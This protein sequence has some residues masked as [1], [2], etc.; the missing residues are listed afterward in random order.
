MHGEQTPLKRPHL[1]TQ[2]IPLTPSPLKST[3]DLSIS[4]IQSEKSI[5][6]ESKNDEQIK[7]TNCTPIR[8]NRNERKPLAERLRP[9]E[10]NDF[11]V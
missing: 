10:F 1:E 7:S 4:S 8:K 3:L 9:S 5:I 2:Q 11:V 6:S